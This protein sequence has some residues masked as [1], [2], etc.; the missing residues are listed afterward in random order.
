MP[1]PQHANAL[2]HWGSGTHSSYI[3]RKDLLSHS[4]N[5]TSKN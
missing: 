5:G 3:P 2:P 4:E 1:A